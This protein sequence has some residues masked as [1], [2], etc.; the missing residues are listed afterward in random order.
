[1]ELKG[2]KSGFVYSI[3]HC[4][5]RAWTAN[6]PTCDEIPPRGTRDYSLNLSDGTW[7]WPDYLDWEQEEFWVRVGLKIYPTPLAQ[8]YGVF[9]GEAWSDWR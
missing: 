9:I 7:E 3:A 2:K 1:M 6:S 8:E 5:H 4:W